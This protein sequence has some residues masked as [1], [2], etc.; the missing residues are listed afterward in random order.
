MN[1]TEAQKAYIAAFIDGEGT[2]AVNKVKRTANR[3]GFR[4]YS[5]VLIT[6]TNLE[7]LNTIKHWIGTGVIF[8]KDPTPKQLKEFKR[9]KYCYRLAV[10]HTKARELL[11][12]IKDHLI[13]KKQNAINVLKFQEYI[14]GKK[15][16]NYNSYSANKL[17]EFYVKSRV[18]NGASL[19]GIDTIHNYV[20][21]ERT[22]EEIIVP[23]VREKKDTKNYKTCCVE[24]CGALTHSK[25]YCRL[26]WRRLT[27]S[28]TVKEGKAIRN[29]IQCG[30]SIEHLRIDRKT[31]SLSCKG[32][33]FRQ[34]AKKAQFVCEQVG[35]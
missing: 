1:L 8:G 18:L 16:Y 26:H 35:A 2:I 29:C 15:S 11:E 19:K 21:D 30:V 28:K 9:Y 25:G 23:E 31:C 27:E 24:G 12:E 3:S 20:K 22:P 17:H 4:Y 34:Q 14:D 6:N 33:W 5:C 32:K 10:K 7:V 13:I